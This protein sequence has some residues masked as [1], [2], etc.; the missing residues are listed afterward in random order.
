LYIFF[1]YEIMKQVLICFCLLLSFSFNKCAKPEDVEK[2]VNEIYGH[3]FTEYVNH[4][5]DRNLLKINFDSLY[6]S[7]EFYHLDAQ[8]ADLEE[9]LGGPIVH[10]ADLWICAQDYGKDLAARVLKV[11]MDGNKKA[12]VTINIHNFGQDQEEVLI[13]VY[14]RDNWFIDDMFDGTLKERLK[15][16]LKYYKKEGVAPRIK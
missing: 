7:E 13:M 6:Y 15:K 16:E 12:K 3:V 4:F 8:V 2:R 1:A 10:D 9:Q 14:E 11:K 5:D